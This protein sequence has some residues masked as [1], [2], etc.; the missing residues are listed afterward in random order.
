MKSLSTLSSPLEGA[1]SLMTF[2]STFILSKDELLG[3]QLCITTLVTLLV[4]QLIAVLLTRQ[5]VLW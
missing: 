3:L 2:N 5:K 1:A 4:A